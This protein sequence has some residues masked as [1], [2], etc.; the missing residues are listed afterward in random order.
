[1]EYY[2]LKKIILGEFKKIKE[3]ENYTWRKKW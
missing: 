2:N 3:K 1:M